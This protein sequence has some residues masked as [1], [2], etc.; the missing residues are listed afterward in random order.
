MGISLLTSYQGAQIF[1]VLG[2]DDDVISKAFKGT[3]CRVSG[4]LRN[5]L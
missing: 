4:K 5:D 3:P 2:F 1:E